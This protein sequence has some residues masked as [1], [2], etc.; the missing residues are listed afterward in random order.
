LM[1]F[2]LC[3]I[4]IL[5]I[6]ALS[7]M[8]ASDIARRLASFTVT[9]QVRSGPSPCAWQS[10]VTWGVEAP[11]AMA[12]ERRGNPK[13]RRVRRYRGLVFIAVNL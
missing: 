1:G 7:V 10:T 9:L 8:S 2:T 5:G 4:G 12:G 11:S 3:A 13:K 6:C